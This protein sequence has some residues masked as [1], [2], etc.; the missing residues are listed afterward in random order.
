[1]AELSATETT[2]NACCAPEAQASCCEPS[3]KADCCGETR[4]D[5]HR[6][7]SCGCEAGSAA[8]ASAVGS[9]SR[10]ID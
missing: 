5:S 2:A 1:M 4:V 6:A 10:P 7:G 8:D 9:R 3:A